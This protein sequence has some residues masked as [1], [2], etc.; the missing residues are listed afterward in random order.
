MRTTKDSKNPTIEAVNNFQFS[1]IFHLE[2]IQHLQDLFADAHGVASIITQPEGTPITNPSNFCRLCNNIIRKT[3]KGRANCYKSDAIIGKQNSS[4]PI[5]QPCLSG[6]LWDAGASITVGGKHIANWLIGQVRNEEVDEPRM[7]QYADEIGAN[8]ADFMEALNEVPV[9]SVEHFNKVAKMLFAFANE[10]SE[11]AYYNLQLKMQ[12]AEWEKATELL[13]KNEERFQLLFNKAPL[14]YQS[15]D[16]DGNFIEVNQHW[17]DTLGYTREEVIGKWFGDFLSPAYQDGFRERFPIF[18]AQG[19]IHSEFEMVH[20]NG[21]KL[22]ISF[23]GKIGYDLNGEFKQTHCILQDITDRKQAEEAL[24]KLKKAIYTSGEAIFLTDREGVFTFVNPAFTT[25][26]GFS[27]DEIVGKTT[28]RII[29]S[30]VLDKSVYEV[31]WQ[32]LLNGDEVR[33]EIINK[34]K[35]GTLIT[36]DSSATPVF[37]EEKNV[38]G[39]LGIQRDITQRKQA[40]ETLRESESKFTAAF[41]SNPVA[42]VILSLDGKFVDTNKSFCELVG[43]SREEVINEAITDFGIISTQDR[44]KLVTAIETA[45]GSV[46]NAEVKFHVRDGSLR[47]ILYSVDTITIQGVPYRLFTGID[48][49]GRKEA[50][51]K[52][53]ASEERFRTLFEYIPDG[54]FVADPNGYYVDVNTQGAQMLGYQRDEIIGM[55]LF[56]LVQK[57]LT[58]LVDKDY[59][60]VKAGTPYLR[61][62]EF[63][64]KDG[65]I[66][67]GDLIG[68]TLP[69]GN[70]L[71][72]VRDITERKRAE[73]ALK[74]SEE[75]FRH[76]FEESADPILLLDDT[77]F[78]DCNQS[79]INLLEYTSKY[80][81]LN[82]QPWEISPER[83]PDGML[84]TEKAVL[85]INT[86]LEKGYNRFEWIH[87]KSDGTNFPVEVMLTPITLKGK[88]LF[89]TIWR[90]ISERKRAEEVLKASESKFRTLGKAI[91][92][93]PVSIVITDADGNIEF[94]NDEFV[95]SSQYTLADVTGRKPRIFNV[96]LLPQ[97]EYDAMWEALRNGDIWRGELYNRKKDL[98]HYFEE[99]S[100][101]TMQNPDGSISNY[102][103]VME[104]IT[105]K[106]KIL[107]DLMVAKDQAQESDRLKSAFLA[108]MSHEIRTPMNGILGFTELLKEPDLADDQRMYFVS[109][110]EKSGERLLNIINN[111]IDISKIESGLMK[112]SFSEI[113]VNEYLN[114]ILA[115]F[116]QEAETKNIKLTS[117][118]GLPFEEAFIKTDSEKFYAVLINLVKNALKYTDTGFIEFGYKRVVETQ[119]IA[120]LQHTEYLQ[121]FVK[122]TGIGIPKDRQEAIFERFIQADIV[123]KMA[124]QGAG[125]GLAISKA[126]VEMLGGRIWVESVEENLSV[127]KEGGSTFYFTLPIDPSIKAGSNTEIEILNPVK[128]VQINPEVSGLK[129]LIAEDDETSSELISIMVRKFGNEIIIA[130]TG[131]EAVEACRNN[132]D[133]DLILMDIQ[134]PE[135]SGYEATRQ[136]RQFNNEV[137]IIALTAFALAGD[138]EKAIKAGCNDYISKPVKKDE[139]IGLIQK[140]FKK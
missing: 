100:I 36:I 81:F 5:M 135:M 88:Q 137:I 96:G 92:Q 21:N 83:Q 16:F 103:L 23:E 54:I 2:D 59:R 102:I 50:E 76:L 77:G 124:R 78:T 104:D 116:N 140:Y 39:F 35:D 119:C 106:K 113:N 53:R 67:Q 31:F 28:P 37:D 47:N 11:K 13:Q 123:D 130:E 29:K 1:D 7:I 9:M 97:P 60:E 90:D 136:I 46:K 117:K 43:Y 62:W 131:T 51:E 8:R 3:E 99:V 127:G 69:K 33:G 105:E 26:Y 122:D 73:I 132:P 139:L 75:I 101:S 79:T 27:S 98:T 112:P 128:E 91:G 32:T 80:E 108:N 133:I 38:I 40:E 66:L 111:I 14:G 129:I 125:L 45:G 134:M 17:L 87:V 57:E 64:R 41:H 15:L 118:P 86:A 56:D 126:Y 48:I 121:F 44:E 114:N 24:V 20:K 85:M 94:V 10:L 12:I 109:I 72:I 61:E 58:S 65:S 70:V 52:L 30:G 138:R 110:I 42:M 107:D 49:T 115:F 25:L 19:K 6:G 71:G 120:S 89:Y 95:V 63:K 4:G 34:R 93:S 82:K 68:T 18:K 22:F 84:S 55:H 74:E